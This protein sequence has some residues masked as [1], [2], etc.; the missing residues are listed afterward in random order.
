MDVCQLPSKR[1]FQEKQEWKP[2]P[3]AW[4]AV[5]DSI[6]VHSIANGYQV[7]AG[8]REDLTIIT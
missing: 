8:Q 3:H 2:P 4:W 7:M 6:P 1:V 5:P